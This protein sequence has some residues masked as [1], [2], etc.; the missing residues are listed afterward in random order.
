MFKLRASHGLLCHVSVH[1]TKQ[2]RHLLVYQLVCQSGRNI[3]ALLSLQGEP[4]CIDTVKKPASNLC[5]SHTLQQNERQAICLYCII[6]MLRP[7]WEMRYCTTRIRQCLHHQQGRKPTGRQAGGTW[8]QWARGTPEDVMGTWWARPD[9][10]SV[11]AGAL[12]SVSAA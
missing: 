9:P 11:A 5:S 1:E 2:A 8:R 3:A 6:Q 10:A 4:Q 12:I 7:R